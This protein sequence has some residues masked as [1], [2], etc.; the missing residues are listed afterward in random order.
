[1][2]ISD[3]D[4]I[5]EAEEAP[6]I[7]GGDYLSTAYSPSTGTYSNSG[8]TYGTAIA[9]QNAALKICEDSARSGD[10]RI[11][12]TTDLSDHKGLLQAISRA[13][14]QGRSHCQRAIRGS[15]Q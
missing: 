1:M 3:L 8:R 7:Q 11:T 6:S 15:H 9:S 12:S 10:C 4:H 2:L 5:E 14:I 13:R